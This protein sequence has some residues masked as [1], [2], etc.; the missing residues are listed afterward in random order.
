[1]IYFKTNNTECPANIA[2]KVTD[3][4]WGGRDSKAVAL[5]MTHAAAVQQ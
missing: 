2:G 5:E 3:Q 1:M 4:D